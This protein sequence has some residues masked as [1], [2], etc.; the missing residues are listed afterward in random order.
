MDAPT[1]VSTLLTALKDLEQVKQV[2]SSTEGP[3][4]KGRADLAEGTFLSFF[5]NQTTGTQAFALVKGSERKWGI[6]YDNARGWHR[7]PVQN[8]D[9]HETIEPQSISAIV[10][11]LKR[12]LADETV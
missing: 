8:P 6:D 4:V 7:H 5:Y 11:E 12:I 9:E 2:S 3:V 10:Q 1:F